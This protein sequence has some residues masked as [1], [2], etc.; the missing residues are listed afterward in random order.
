MDLFTS[1]GVGDATHLMSGIN[2]CVTEVMNQQL[3]AQFM[4]KE[5]YV[6]LKLIGPSKA[7]RFDGFPPLFFQ[8]YWSIV[9]E[10]VLNFALGV[11]NNSNDLELVNTIDIVL[12]PKLSNHVN[13][14]NFRPISLCF[15]PYKIV[16]KMLTNIL[17][18]VIDKC[19]DLVRCAFVSGHLTM[20]NVLVAYEL[21]HDFKQKRMGRT[22]FMALKLDMAK[23][24]I[25]SSDR[26]CVVLCY[27]WV[28]LLCGLI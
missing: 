24:M 2:A 1:N 12:I 26:S 28:L 11:L 3:T 8:R 7:P 16:A 5:V 22:G 15:V 13:L 27:G 17:Q 9:M 19:I 23:L 10:D 6:A 18:S 21:H 4:M 20:D 25:G 14:R